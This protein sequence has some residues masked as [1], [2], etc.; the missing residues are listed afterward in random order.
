MNLFG[1]PHERGV[2]LSV[3]GDTDTHRRLADM[4]L[5]GSRYTVRVRRR[6]ALL[7]DYGVFCAVTGK[8]IAEIITV[9]QE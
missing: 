1:C 9:G 4:G 3:G 8:A 5:L 2:I 7:V 6:G